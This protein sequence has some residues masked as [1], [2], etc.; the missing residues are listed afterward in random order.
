MGTKLSEQLRKEIESAGY[1]ISGYVGGAPKKRYFTPDGREIWR[2]SS[3]RQY[4]NRQTGQGGERDANYD[5]GLLDQKPQ[6][7]LPYCP[8]CDRWHNTQEEIDKCG[9][10][11]HTLISKHQVLAEKQLEKQDDKRITKLESDISELKDMFKQVLN[12]LGG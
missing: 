11:K 3:I 5:E 9:S 1:G 12:K 6:N 10:K 7:L 2:Q 4:V 8:H